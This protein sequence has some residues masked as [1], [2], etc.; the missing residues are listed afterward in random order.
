M[1]KMV[2]S[3]RHGILGPNNASRTV[4]ECAAMLGLQLVEE[5]PNNTVIVS[6][7]P[8]SV[9]RGEM[10]EAF[11]DFGKIEDGAVASNARGFG[12]Y[13]CMLW[14]DTRPFLTASVKDWCVFVRQSLLRLQ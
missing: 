6:G 7:M 10:M 12:T 1:N 4:H 11:E 3:V 5:L 13:Q 9:K 8:K 2:S 14:K